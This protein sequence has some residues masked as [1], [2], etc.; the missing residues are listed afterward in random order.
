MMIRVERRCLMTFPG[1]RVGGPLQ[2]FSKH[3]PPST[4]RRVFL[5]VR[6]TKKTSRRLSPRQVK[7]MVG[8][9]GPGYR[10]VVRTRPQAD[11]E[12]TSHQPGECH[13]SSPQ[14]PSPAKVTTDFLFH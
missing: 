1:Q 5:H 3:P 14:T 10:S 12:G 11:P 4:K 7:G 6:D 2:S 13:T 8:S 9:W